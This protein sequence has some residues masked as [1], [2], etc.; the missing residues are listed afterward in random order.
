MMRDAE[1]WGE[2]TM[3]YNVSYKRVI[4]RMLHFGVL[5]LFVFV[6]S[7]GASGPEDSGA[8]KGTVWVAKKEHTRSTV[9][10]N[11]EVSVKE[12]KEIYVEFMEWIDGVYSIRIHWW[13]VSAGINVMEYGV[14][15][16]HGDGVFEYNEALH[17]EDSDFPGLQGRGRF[18]LLDDH[19][20]TLSQLGHLLDGSA[21]AFVTTLHKTDTA[22]EIPIDLTYPPQSK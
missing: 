22:P 13:N 5:L 12:G 17:H 16:P 1:A 4:T 15:V 19:T 2:R 10:I 6:T 3:K 7:A 9:D 21:S 11:G 18:K 20:A 14:M 8:L